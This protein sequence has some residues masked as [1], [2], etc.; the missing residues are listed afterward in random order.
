M[1]TGFSMI[2]VIGDIRGQ[3][4]LLIGLRGQLAIFF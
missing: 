1:D 2:R 3:N 4:S